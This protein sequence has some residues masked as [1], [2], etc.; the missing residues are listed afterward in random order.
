MSTLSEKLLRARPILEVLQGERLAAALV[1][2]G[3]LA[4]A[5]SMSELKPTKI[6]AAAWRDFSPS[7]GR[8][9]CLMA[10]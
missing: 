4:L 7:I 3:E 6:A 1:G 10:R 8:E 2:E 5:D 9:P